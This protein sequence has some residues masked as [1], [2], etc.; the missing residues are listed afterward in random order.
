MPPGPSDSVKCYQCS[1]LEG[2]QCDGHYPGEQVRFGQY[3]GEQVCLGSFG[4]TFADLADFFWIIRNWNW[5][6]AISMVVNVRSYG[7]FL[8]TGGLS[9]KWWLSHLLWWAESALLY[10]D[11]THIDKLNLFQFWSHLI[12]NEMQEQC[13]GDVQTWN[14]SLAALAVL[15]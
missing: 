2:G 13:M 15:V 6:P 3:P 1:S 4:G 12:F 7:C 5:P 9:C 11:E 8:W 14:L 10:L